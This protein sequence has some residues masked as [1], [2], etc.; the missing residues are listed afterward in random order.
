MLQNT[1]NVLL[2]CY[3]KL[4]AFS[5]IEL[6]ISF[7]TIAI[8]LAAFSPV[9]SKKLASSATSSSGGSSGGVTYKC[10]TLFPD[11]D[12]ACMLCTKNPKK[13]IMC[14]K[15]CPSGEY[16][17]VFECKC[18]SC[19]TKHSDSHCVNCD[20]NSCFGCS[21]GYSLDSNKKCIICPAG[22][23]CID[24]TVK[25]C[26]IGTYSTGGAT[27]CVPCSSGTMSQEG[28]TSCSSCSD[29]YANCLSCDSSGCSACESG[30][31]LV[32]GRCQSDS[33][34]PPKTLQI[35]LS[36][37]ILCITQYNIGDQPEFPLSSPAVTGPLDHPENGCYSCCWQGKTASS[38]D[39][40]N[41]GYSGCNRT[42]CTQRGAFNACKNLNYA[43]LTW[44]L[45]YESE[46]D[47]IDV[48]NYSV[49]KGVNGL[50]L[51]NS[52]ADYGSALCSDNETFCRANGSYRCSPSG[53][54]TNSY[55]SGLGNDY[56]YRG[57]LAGGNWNV[58]YTN[59]T[60]NGLSVR[61]VA[62]IDMGSCAD[63]FGLNCTDCT[64]TG[65]TGC[66]EGYA[67]V[68]NLCVLKPVCKDVFGESCA[69]CSYFSCT[70]CEDGYK[71]VD[72]QCLVP[73]C[74][75]NTIK[76][77]VSGKD[78]CVTQY[79]MGDKTEFPVNAF[80][81]V[82]V[83][84]TNSNCSAYACCWQGQTASPCNSDN[85][86]YS[87]CNRTV[88]TQYAAEIICDNLNYG[89]MTWRLPTKAELA[90]FD[91]DTYSKN[92]GTSGLML[93]DYDSGYG[94]AQ[95][96]GYSVCVGDSSDICRPD[97]VWSSTL[98][99]SWSGN[100]YNY[101]LDSGSWSETFSYG[102]YASSVRCVSE[103]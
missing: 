63:R 100:A 79:N 16:K 57:S 99:Y 35:V 18:E 40:A 29:I 1:K 41:G 71:F 88:C 30:Y 11:S 92:L 103:L 101:Y 98:Y 31:K 72:G 47:A 77:T 68:D 42:V 62:S 70:L 20:E 50:M 61:C 95:C 48:A 15:T 9:I 49:N 83:V 67:L 94:S 90:G 73:T 12:G 36:D 7:I 26:P 60:G 21:D 5:L 80:S 55:P 23:Y 45:P 74:P 56:I 87:G 4:F 27:A 52:K 19:S 86:G 17:N 10:S 64:T 85:G 66:S 97:K 89:G 54:W 22:S 14:S 65:C 84:P 43:G 96:N 46:L 53:I 76:I 28:A 69:E 33:L 6:G 37:K 13:C 3:R 39:S 44:R 25:K 34:C 59:G 38:C 81:G 58:S 82:T 93:C 91:P 2:N 32:D 8:L 78:L 102:K 24:G 75:A 51:C